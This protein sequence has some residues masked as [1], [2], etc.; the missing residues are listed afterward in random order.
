MSNIEKLIDILYDLTCEQ[1]D[2]IMVLHEEQN[3][4]KVT[5]NMN[6]QEHIPKYARAMVDINP[7]AAEKMMVCLAEALEDKEMEK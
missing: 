3:H 1:N 7:K 4:T 6:S 2:N 5:M